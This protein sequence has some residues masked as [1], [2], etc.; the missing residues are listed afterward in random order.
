MNDWVLVKDIAAA[1]GMTLPAVLYS[2]TKF[3]VDVQTKKSGIFIHADKVALLHKAIDSQG[4]INKLKA[5]RTRLKE[6]N[7]RLFK[8]YKNA[9]AKIDKELSEASEAVKRIESDF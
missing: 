9:K 8:E 7:T 2:V 1:R 6:R 3:N 5:H 4:E